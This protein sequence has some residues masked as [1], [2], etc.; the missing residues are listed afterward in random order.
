MRVAAF[1]AAVA[2]IVA[3]AGQV[4]VLAARLAGGDLGGQL[5]TAELIGAAGLIAFV[6]LGAVYFII[7]AVTDRKSR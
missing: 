7:V 3:V 6:A 1:W 4:A 2:G 5:A